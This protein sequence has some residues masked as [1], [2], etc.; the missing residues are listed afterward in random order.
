MCD[1]LAAEAKAWLANRPPPKSDGK[2][3]TKLERQPVV[4]VKRKRHI[5][6]KQLS[7]EVRGAWEKLDK[8]RRRYRYWCPRMPRGLSR[9]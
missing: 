3:P 8:L 7:A 9:R 1:K 5:C 6:P 2:P 4:V